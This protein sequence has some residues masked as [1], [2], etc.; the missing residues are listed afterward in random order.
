MKFLILILVFIPFTSLT[1]LNEGYIQF[2]IDVQ[3]IDT[4][5]NAQQTAAMMRNSRM[6][7]F[8]AEN[9]SRVDF[10]LGRMSQT[11]VRIN[12]ETNEGVSLAETVMG[13]F[14]NVG[15]AEELAGEQV[16]VSMDNVKITPFNEFKT[17]LGFKCQ[18]YVMDNNGVYTTYWITDE[19]EIGDLG[20]QVVNPNLPGFPLAFT[21]INNGIRMH[22]QAS[23]YKDTLDNKV[24]IFSMKVPE[25]FKIIDQE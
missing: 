5:K 15:T 7:I 13:K 20:Q 22:F 18:K 10:T 16:D 11:S 21:S 25:D 19:I 2:D 23:N 24:S 14:A 4:S 3:A 17:I 6:D 12:R 9:R 8:F 1:Q